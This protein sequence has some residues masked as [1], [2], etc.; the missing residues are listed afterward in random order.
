MGFP[1]QDQEEDVIPA[2]TAFTTMISQP[3]HPPFPV[4]QLHEGKGGGG[5][6]PDTT[7]TQTKLLYHNLPLSD[8]GS[9]ASKINLKAALQV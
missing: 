9:S 6:Q 1:G 2:S 8:C 4:R 5:L 3:S 7:Q